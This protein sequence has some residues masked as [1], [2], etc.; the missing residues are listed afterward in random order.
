MFSLDTPTLAP[1]ML[2]MRMS[3]E[4]TCVYILMRRAS[5]WLMT[6]I[7]CHTRAPAMKPA[8]RS[9]PVSPC[10]CSRCNTVI[11]IIYSQR[12]GYLTISWTWNTWSRHI[13]PCLES[14][15]GS[16]LMIFTSDS[17]SDSVGLSVCLSLCAQNISKSSERI[18]KKI[19]TG[20][21]H[22]AGTNRLDLGDDSDSFVDLWQNSLPLAA[23]E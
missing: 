12:L 2:Q 6:I 23:R 13:H 14:K 1:L 21:G 22:G 19:F 15:C 3:V 11:C 17:S 4:R 10:K 9:I 20:L 8:T 5:T 16:H 18:M 7:A